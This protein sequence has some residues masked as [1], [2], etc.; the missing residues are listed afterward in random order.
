MYGNLDGG[1]AVNS[2]ISCLWCDEK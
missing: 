1:H 2:S